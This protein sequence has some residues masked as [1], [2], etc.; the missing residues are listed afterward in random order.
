MS[1]KVFCSNCG[2]ELG[3]EQKFCANCGAA[4]EGNESNK[5]EKKVKKKGKKKF[6]FFGGIVVIIAS[7]LALSGGKKYKIEVRE[8][9]K[10]IETKEDYDAMQKGESVV[11]VIKNLERTTEGGCDWLATFVE[12]NSGNRT[13]DL[14]GFSIDDK[15]ID[16]SKEETWVISGVYHETQKIEDGT[17]TDIALLHV[18][19]Y[20]LPTD[21]VKELGTIN[22]SAGTG[23]V[24]ENQNQITEDNKEHGDKKDLY[25]Y[26]NATEEVLINELEFEANDLGMY[27]N[28]SD[29]MVICLEG[30]VYSITLTEDDKDKYSFLGV[31]IGEDI[32]CAKEKLSVFYTYVDTYAIDGNMLRDVFSDNEFGTL[33]IDYDMST[34]QIINVGYVAESMI[35]PETEDLQV[36]EQTQEKIDYSLYEYLINETINSYGEDSTYSIVDIDSDGILEMIISHGTCDADW[37]NTVYTIDGENGVFYVGD[38]Y[39][40]AEFYFSDFSVTDDGEGIIAVSGGGGMENID[41]IT[42]NGFELTVNNVVYREMGVDDN[43]YGNEMY[44]PWAYVTDTSLLP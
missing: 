3:E 41:Q 18:Y 1:K 25:L 21:S 27:P 42:K 31:S 26:R 43:F 6:I 29:L 30:K 17:N 19:D 33:S 13:G 12:T 35:V 4:V 7:I 5:E 2:K 36:E 34:Y 38:F 16:F 14:V 22:T 8:G 39:R 20:R 28:E 37:T 40:P 23:I 10:L 15:D 44:I 11:M 9:E 32:N 24:E